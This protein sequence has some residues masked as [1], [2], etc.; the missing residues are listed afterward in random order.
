MSGNRIGFEEISGCWGA[1]SAPLW[2]LHE[3]Q[4][5]DPSWSSQKASDLS[6]VLLSRFSFSFFGLVR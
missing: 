4:S 3:L 6:L 1:C 5:L 2:L